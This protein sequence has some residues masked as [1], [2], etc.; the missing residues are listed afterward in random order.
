MYDVP[1]SDIEDSQ[2]QLAHPSNQKRKSDHDR[3]SSTNEDRPSKRPNLWSSVSVPRIRASEM[4]GILVDRHTRVL[5]GPRVPADKRP[6]HDFTNPDTVPD[7]Y[8]S[9]G[10]EPVSAQAEVDQQILNDSITQSNVDRVVQEP[11]VSI[12]DAE[13]ESIPSQSENS[14]SESSGLSKSAPK[15]AAESQSNASDVDDAAEDDLSESVS[16]KENIEPTARNDKS[17]TGDDRGLHTGSTSRTKNGQSIRQSL[18]EVA[19]PVIQSSSAGPLKPLEILNG[20]RRNN[21]KQN[22]RLTSNGKSRSSASFGNAQGQSPEL[23]QG[24]QNSNGKSRPESNPLLPPEAGEPTVQSKSAKGK[25][26]IAR[27]QAVGAQLNSKALDAEARNSQT[28]QSS[29]ETR[30][31][32][33]SIHN[34]FQGAQ[35]PSLSNHKDQ[36]K[37]A[38]TRERSHS[39]SSEGSEESRRMGLGITTSPSHRRTSSIASSFS[40]P[41]KKPRKSR[42]KASEDR[43]SSTVPHPEGDKDLEFSQAAKKAVPDSSKSQS[44]KKNEKP[45]VPGKPNDKVSR[46]QSSELSTSSGP[47]LPPGYSLERYQQQ[48]AS[49]DSTKA[50]A[51][52]TQ[53][54]KRAKKQPTSKSS[55]KDTKTN[56]AGS[57]DGTNQNPKMTKVADMSNARTTPLADASE[58]EKNGEGRDIKD[59]D[60][61]Q[62]IALD[63]S[64]RVVEPTV[65]AKEV[66]QA[67]ATIPVPTGREQKSKTT[68]QKPTPP[69]AT[70][71]IRK[72]NS[73]TSNGKTTAEN[74]NGISDV[75]SMSSVAKPTLVKKGNILYKPPRFIGS[76]PPK[77]TDQPSV[78]P[79]IERLPGLTRMLREQQEAARRKAAE[80]ERQRAQKS[81]KPSTTSSSSEDDDDS[82]DTESTDESDSDDNVPSKV[83][84]GT[85]IS[86]RVNGGP[87]TSLPTQGQGTEEV[88]KATSSHPQEKH[89]KGDRTST[90]ASDENESAD[91]TDIVKKDKTPPPKRNTPQKSGY[92]KLRFWEA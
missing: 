4:N 65:T 80:Q 46:R 48:L 90:S 51:S 78:L 73:K 18:K 47:F 33:D 14:K 28:P 42:G 92:R 82:D 13:T 57:G 50:Q 7:E 43:G 19:I 41:S 6:V 63:Q 49:F 91:D 89:V 26:E 32:K 66:N 55:S 72:K 12:S 58:K 67:K 85:P 68:S 10:S 8:Q 87:A 30:N 5:D 62:E 24:G 21:E 59:R 88:M 60:F 11:E 77:Q 61:E 76:S 22:P 23:S 1:E 70:Q 81:I 25:R 38:E 53:A 17:L 37:D 27:D 29:K 54:P 3:S 83:G 52:K 34:Y 75:E 86:P 64:T 36:E 35:G 16:E 74:K 84:K 79:S 39:G 9:E 44:S 2:V 20:I 45:T 71:D 15:S 56:S 69:A 31:V 40:S